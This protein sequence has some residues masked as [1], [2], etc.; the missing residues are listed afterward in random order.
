MKCFSLKIKQKYF[1]ETKII[2]FF[3]EK[4]FLLINFSNSK[5][6]Q[7]SLERDIQKTTFH[8][9]DGRRYT[10]ISHIVPEDFLNYHHI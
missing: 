3:I 6:I 1:S 9:T 5:Q 7:K 2:F 4:Y 10:I 8:E